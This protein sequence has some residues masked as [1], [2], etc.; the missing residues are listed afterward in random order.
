MTLKMI[1]KF[2]LKRFL[3]LFDISGYLMRLDVHLNG[4]ASQYEFEFGTGRI[5]D[6]VQFMEYP[7]NYHHFQ[8]KRGLMAGKLMD[9]FCKIICHLCIM[10]LSD[11][12]SFS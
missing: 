5:S 6:L 4:S 12:M 2:S 8:T 11:G 1:L 9:W 10:I 7:E 3:H